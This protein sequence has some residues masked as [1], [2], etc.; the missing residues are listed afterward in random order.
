MEPQSS[1]Q[2]STG[3]ANG[4]HPQGKSVQSTPSQPI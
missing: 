2:Y 4:P 3:P 1:S